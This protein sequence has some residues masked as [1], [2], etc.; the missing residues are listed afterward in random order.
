MSG[1]LLCNK[2][3]KN[4]YYI[5]DIDINVYSIEEISYF[6]Y[7]H[8][9]LVGTDFF[10]KDLVSYICNELELKQLAEALNNLIQSN[11]ALGEMV[12]FVLKESD[13][14]NEKEIV[15]IEKEIQ[16][17]NGNS[18]HRRLKAKADLLYNC[19]KYINAFYVYKKILELPR[20]QDLTE[21]FYA[22]TLN[23]IGVIF[24][25][26]L[27]YDEAEK[28]FKSAYEHCQEE[29]YL[30][31]IVMVDEMSNNEK[32]LL[33]NI[34]SYNISDELLKECKQEYIRECEEA[35]YQEE[36]V[37]LMELVTYDKQ[38]AYKAG[39]HE[40]LDHWKADYR[41]LF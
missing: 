25:K 28:Y 27:L 11:A 34:R 16:N 23:N 3:S 15:Q 39:L 2:Q 17:I 29:I 20:E 1:L 9:Y 21:K 7:H 31:R 35:E 41:E 26:L 12:L 4:P 5:S 18:L 8:I 22:D 38:D 30:K 19:N 24:I 14:Y 6:L 32:N 40:T 36:Y 10:C 13:Y 33:G 37:G